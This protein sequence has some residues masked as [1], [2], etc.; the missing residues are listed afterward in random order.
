MP[1]EP[2]KDLQPGDCKR[3]CGVQPQPFETMRHVLPDHAQQTATPGRP[4][5]LAREAQLCMSLPY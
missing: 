2:M 3:A 1:Y 4:S 5:K